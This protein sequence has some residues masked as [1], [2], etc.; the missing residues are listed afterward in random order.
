M[1]F[2]NSISAAK[3][4]LEKGTLT[5]RNKE[6]VFKPIKKEAVKDIK[7]KAP[8]ATVPSIDMRQ[9][10]IHGDIAKIRKDLLLMYL[11][12]EKKSGGGK[13]MSENLQ[14]NPP[15]VTFVDEKGNEL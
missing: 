2:A 3:R 15:T 1:K 6:L 12:S 4:I 5:L 11:E 14:A 8:S 10:E 9:V 7:R 13:M